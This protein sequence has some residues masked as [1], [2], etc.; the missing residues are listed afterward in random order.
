ML[1]HYLIQI[2][3]STKKMRPDSFGIRPHFFIFSIG[4]SSKDFWQMEMMMN[5]EIVIYHGA[6]IK[7]F[8]KLP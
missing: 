1:Y 5:M 3:K 6:K 7:T 2:E 4:S 8:G